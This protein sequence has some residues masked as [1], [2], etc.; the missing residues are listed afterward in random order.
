MP[1]GGAAPTTTWAAGEVLP[2]AITLDLPPD[3][4]PGPHHLLIAFYRL[5]TGE[6]LHLPGGADHLKLPLK[7]NSIP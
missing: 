4:G 1:L 2:D 3:L 5:E 7:L 6:R